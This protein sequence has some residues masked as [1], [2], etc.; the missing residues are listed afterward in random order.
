[1]ISR[2]SSS[3]LLGQ[4]VILSL[5]LYALEAGA[6]PTAGGDP[7]SAYKAYRKAIHD[8]ASLK[9][10]MPYLTKKNQDEIK[11]VPPGQ[12]NMALALMKGIESGKFK[13]VRQERK[14]KNTVVLHM[15]V[16]GDP[17][18]T[19]VVIMKREFG[20]WKVDKSSWTTK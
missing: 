13:V 9:E 6:Y 10:I 1:M 17:R 20:R 4:V 19:G 14:G 2:F 5:M 7:V 8:A 11:K 12:A 16:P 18:T 3:F 15:I